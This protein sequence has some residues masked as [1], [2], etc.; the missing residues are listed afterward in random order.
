MKFNAEKLREK[1][2]EK[3]LSITEMSSRMV[4]ANQQYS[5]IENGS[6]TPTIKTINRIASALGISAKSLLS[7]N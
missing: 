7:E 6:N 4:M 1:R 2:I 5:S 3:G